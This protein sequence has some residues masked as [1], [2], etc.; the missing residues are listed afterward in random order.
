MAQFQVF[1]KGIYVN[2]QTILAVVNGMPKFKDL[3]FM[4][5]SENGLQNIHVNQWYSMQSWLN[6]FKTIAE[7][8]GEKTLFEIGKVIPYSADFPSDITTIE[9]GLKSIDIAYHI[10]HSKNGKDPMYNPQTR[11]MQEGIGHYIF[12][13]TGN[14]SAKIIGSNPYP[15]EFD[16]GIISAMAQKYKPLAIVNIDL[17]SENRK[18]GG[19]TTTYIIKW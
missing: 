3:A 12:E 17:D 1:E 19:K 9:K 18:S 11:E 4:I 16:R 7:E 5:L 13:S 15:C 10:N 8:I 2:G 6:A 14:N